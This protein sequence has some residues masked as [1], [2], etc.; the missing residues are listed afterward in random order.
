MRCLPV[1]SADNGRVA[2]AAELKAKGHVINPYSSLQ[3]RGLQGAINIQHDE[4]SP[5]PDLVWPVGLHTRACLTA[6]KLTA[7]EHL[8]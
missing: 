4:P 6:A 1:W 8:H 5:E 7:W 3:E 2:D